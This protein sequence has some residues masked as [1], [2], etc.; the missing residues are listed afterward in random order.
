MCLYPIPSATDPRSK[1]TRSKNSVR[2]VLSFILASKTVAFRETHVVISEKCIAGTLLEG[3]LERWDLPTSTLFSSSLVAGTRTSSPG[4]MRWVE[5]YLYFSEE[6]SCRDFMWNALEL[7]LGQNKWA[8]VQAQGG[9]SPL[10]STTSITSLLTALW[11]NA[12]NLRWIE[13]LTSVT[14][15]N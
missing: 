9:A 14:G 8:V 15:F 5:K 1:R 3:M 10:L 7:L 13:S 2:Q 6:M 11:I 12:S 4:E